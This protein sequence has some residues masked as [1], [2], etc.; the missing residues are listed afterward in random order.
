MNEIDGR[1]D[2]IHI[3]HPSR[4]EGVEKEED[5]YGEWYS[6]SINLLKETTV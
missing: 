3:R 6:K 4:N 1:I 5:Y 2:Q